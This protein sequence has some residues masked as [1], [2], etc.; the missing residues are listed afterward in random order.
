MR[1]TIFLSIVKYIM[2]FFFFWFFDKIERRLKQVYD[3]FRWKFYDCWEFSS[4]NFIF[5]IFIFIKKKRFDEIFDDKN[6]E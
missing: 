4:L 6:Q 2:V 5:S 1:I 3:T